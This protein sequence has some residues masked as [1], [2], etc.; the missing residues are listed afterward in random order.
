MLFLRGT[1][2]S[3]ISLSALNKRCQLR[4]ELSVAASAGCSYRG[5]SFWRAVLIKAVLS[6]CHGFSVS[7]HDT[8]TAQS[9]Q[10]RRERCRAFL[11]AAP[12]AGEAEGEH[13]SACSAVAVQG[14]FAASKRDFTG[15]E[16]LGTAVSELSETPGARSE[17]LLP[18]ERD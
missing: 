10:P 18:P 2:G 13:S 6:G 17:P 5:T 12:G 16:M 11:R 14:C 3:R 9:W 7:N 8:G 15:R 1:E 4:A